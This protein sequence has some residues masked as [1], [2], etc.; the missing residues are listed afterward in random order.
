MSRHSNRVI[1]AESQAGKSGWGSHLHDAWPGGYVKASSREHGLL[2]RTSVFVNTKRVNYISGPRV[3]HLGK[4]WDLASR[5]RHAAPS[6]QRY[7]R[8][9]VWEPPG[10]GW[11]DEDAQELYELFTTAQDIATEAGLPE[12][13]QPWLH[14]VLDEIGRWDKQTIVR[15]L[16]ESVGKGIIVTVIGQ[17]MYDAPK[18]SRQNL[19]TRIFLRQA[20]EG[21]S[22]IA[23]TYDVE[24][25]RQVER[26]VQRDYHAVSYRPG[27]IGWRRHLP[28]PDPQA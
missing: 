28:L 12:G 22:D 7:W 14:I 16:A 2:P 23:D 21:Y 3:Q 6:Q 19:A 20:P 8:S 15:I 4:V 26:W 18:D 5:A 13:G 10:K 11:A 9:P 27:G 24:I 25:R 1:N 17:R